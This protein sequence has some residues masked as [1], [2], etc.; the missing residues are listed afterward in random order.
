MRRLLCCQCTYKFSVCKR[1]VAA[2]RPMRA[3]ATVGGA[4]LRSNRRRDHNIAP[5][6]QKPAL[7]NKLACMKS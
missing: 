4:M 6:Y 5:A 7:G 3:A 2:R 1:N